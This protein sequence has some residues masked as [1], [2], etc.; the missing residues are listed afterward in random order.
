MKKDEVKKVV[1]EYLLAKEKARVEQSILIS[2]RVCSLVNTA[3]KEIT[4]V[5]FKNLF[6]STQYR[7]LSRK[8]ID[9]F[10]VDEKG[11]VIIFDTKIDVFK[12]IDML[13][14]N[15]K[16]MKNNA[17]AMEIIMPPET[18][19]VDNCIERLNELFNSCIKTKSL[20]LKDIQFKG[21][22]EYNRYIH[23][24][25]NPTQDGI[26]M[27][28]YTLLTKDYVFA[29]NYS[30]VIGKWLQDEYYYDETNEIIVT[31]DKEIIDIKYLAKKT[32][33]ECWLFDINGIFGEP[34]SR[35][36]KELNPL[37]IKI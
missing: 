11:D 35:E 31:S 32:E 6:S 36:V 13:G 9:K 16:F 1:E 21:Y 30:K 25:I 15:L 37:C 12:Y 28:R 8:A 26:D 3:L 7:V 29:H 24:L 22:T 19:L 17:E 34:T 27:L 2:K 33:G 4:Y 5:S 18:I 23:G 14:H 10:R 20:R